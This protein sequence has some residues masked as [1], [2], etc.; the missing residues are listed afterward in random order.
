MNVRYRVELSQAEREELTGMLS[1]GK[2]AARKL[3]RAQILLAA[4]IGSRDEE[5]ARTVRV[6]AS[7]VYRTKRR[8]V[9]GNLDRALSEEPRPGAERKLTGKEE[10]L[11]VATACAKPRYQRTFLHSR[12]NAERSSPLARFSCS[13]SVGEVRATFVDRRQVGVYR[14]WLALLLDA[15]Q[16]V[17]PSFGLRQKLVPRPKRDDRVERVGAGAGW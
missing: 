11:L 17:L 3:K 6:S 10:A 12:Q 14:T 5:I 15:I 1:G 2:H 8:F 4:D 16:S 7:T 9:E 13:W